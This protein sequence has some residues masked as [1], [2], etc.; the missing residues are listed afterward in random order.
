MNRREFIELL[1]G[2]AAWPFAARAQT[3]GSAHKIGYL[4]PWSLELPSYTLGL[5]RPVWQKLGYVEGETLLLRSAADLSRLPSL[6]AELINLGAGVLIV[7]GPGAVRATAQATKIIPIVAIALETDPVRAGLAASINRPGGNVTG[8]FLD[9]PSLAGKWLQ[10]LRETAPDIERVAL[11]WDP[12]SGTDQLDAARAAA[13]RM[14]LEALV[15]EMRTSEEYESEF[16]KLGMLGSAPRTGIIQLASPIL[17]SPYSRLSE[18][19]LRHRFPT[20]S[21]FKPQAKAGALMSYG[22]NLEAYYPR[23]AILADKIVKG[24]RPA[25]LPIEQ[26]DRFELVINLKTAKALGREVPASLLAL[27]DELIE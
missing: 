9:Q 23:A 21:F 3:Q 11:I 27:A 25:E 6:V 1:G 12:N 24:A 17:I 22:P 26:P 13:A 15:L 4:H 16:Q 2:I 18:A 8:L 10:L 20:M 19:S 14:G 5:I 7:V